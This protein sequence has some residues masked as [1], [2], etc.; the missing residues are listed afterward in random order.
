MGFFVLQWF[1]R[2]NSYYDPWSLVFLSV[3]SGGWHFRVAG[4]IFRGL[5][6]GWILDKWTFV[7]W[8][9]ALINVIIVLSVA[10]FSLSL[11]S[12]SLRPTPKDRGKLARAVAEEN[13]KKMCSGKCHDMWARFT[14]FSL[15][16]LLLQGQAFI[17]KCGKL[18]TGQAN[19][20]T[21]KMTRSSILNPKI[22]LP[23]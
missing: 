3:H 9:C 12:R 10:V 15:F 20:S 2:T 13:P 19:I 6:T 1:F 22:S 4:G 23:K 16:V 8:V 14:R 18:C 5:G 17:T 11:L 21:R 7:R